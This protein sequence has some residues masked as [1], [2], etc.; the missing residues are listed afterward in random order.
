MG[1]MKLGY[2]FAVP[3]ADI[4]MPDHESLT[5]E[6]T[7]LFLKKEA[8]GDAFRND[9]RRDT[10]QGSLF[11]SKFDLFYW[12]EPAAKKLAHFCHSAV[13]SVV[14]GT[15]DY[16]QGEI[17]ALKFDYHAWFHITREGGYQALHNHSNA[18]WSGIFCV[19]PGDQ[20]PERPDSGAVRIYDPRGNA[21]YYLDAGNSRLKMPANHGSYQVTHE[22]G[23]LVLFPSYLFHEV[24]PYQGTKPRIVVAFN[25]WIK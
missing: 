2:L 23:K 7:Q 3:F 5:Q 14:K 11:E 16:T 19:D 25:C 20:V 9:V 8:Q 24:F 15:S 18:S 13:V 22:A 17:E 10:Q 21:S 1:E 6:L 4:H 12:E